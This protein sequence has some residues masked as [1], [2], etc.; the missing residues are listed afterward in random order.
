MDR[1]SGHGGGDIANLFRRRSV[2]RKSKLSLGL[3]P[4]ATIFSPTATW[5]L[6]E[7]LHERYPA[8]QGTE[9]ITPLC[10][11]PQSDRQAANLAP[12]PARP[13]KAR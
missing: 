12:K 11:N 9:A 2:V 4:W 3:A 13:A 7:N 1:H 10:V 6:F 8:N 5:Q